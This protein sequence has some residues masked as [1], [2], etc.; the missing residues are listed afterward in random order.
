MILK[1]LFQRP[2]T[3]ERECYA[4]I[5]AAA[6]H[7]VLYA[8][9]GVEDSLDGRF[10]MIALHAFLVLDRL[11]GADAAFR[12]ALVD[13]LFQDMDRSLR[14]MGVG[15]LSVGKKVRKMA[16]VFYGR[17]AAYDRALAGPEGALTG[18]IARN[19]FPGG[20][21]AAESAGAR[22]LAAYV[23]DQRAHLAGQPVA[24]IVAGKLSFREP[25]P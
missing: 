10:D 20:A 21:D 14:E 25:S 7:P 23:Q 19:V 22:R 3:P 11:K 16:E 17:V 9:C 6:R 13:E 8:G 12:Q 15:D 1:R 5:V 4:A 2:P 18:A 24:A